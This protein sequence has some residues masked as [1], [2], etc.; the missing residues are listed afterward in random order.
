MSIDTKT[1]VCAQCAHWNATAG[2]AGECRRQPPQTLSFSVSGEV[3][4]AIRFPETSST[5]W[6]GEF[7]AK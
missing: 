3:K 5:D 6:C 2:D 4:F 1:E 7:K